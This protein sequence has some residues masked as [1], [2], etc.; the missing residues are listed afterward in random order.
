MEEEAQGAHHHRRF[1]E[2][3][4]DGARTAVGQVDPLDGAHTLADLAA[5]MPA[6]PG[7]IMLPKARGRADVELLDRYLSALEVANGIE[8]GSTR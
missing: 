7:G 1:P 5:I 8:Q 3:R 4:A 2:G 6:R